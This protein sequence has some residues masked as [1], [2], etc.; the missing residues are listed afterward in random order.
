[1]KQRT[2]CSFPQRD[3]KDQFENLFVF[4][5][6]LCNDQEFAEAYVS[7]LYDV[8]PLRDKRDKDLTP[9]EIVIEKEKI[10]V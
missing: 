2:G 6:E 8:N 5:L 3:T 7:G 4:D 1:M 9:V 10:T